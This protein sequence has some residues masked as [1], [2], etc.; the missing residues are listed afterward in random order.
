[1]LKNTPV[2]VFIS[3]P[4]MEVVVYGVDRGWIMGKEITFNVNASDRIDNFM[5]AIA[6]S[7]HIRVDRMVMKLPSGDT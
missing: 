3:F 2:K 7:K 4:R 1:M 5:K 6:E